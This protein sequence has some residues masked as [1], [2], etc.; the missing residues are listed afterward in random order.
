M[1]T[2]ALIARGAYIVRNAAVCGGCHSAQPSDPDGP[3]T[4]GLEFKDW[5]LGTI[6]AANLTPDSAT[7]LGTWSDGE[8]VRA[9]RNGEAKDGRLLAPVMPYT[10][11]REMSDGDA[12][13]VARYLKSLQPV[14]HQVRESPNLMFRIGKLL[15]LGPARGASESTPPRGPTVQY[16]AYLA[17]HVALCAEC[18]TPRS[19]LRAAPDRR[20]LLAGDAHPPKDFPANPANVTPD[21][22]TGIGTWSERDFVGTLR[23]GVDPKGDSLNPFMPWRQFR[24][25]TDA[26]LVAIYHYLR[27]VKPIHHEVP[28]RVTT[29][30]R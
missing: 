27:V 26:D 5:R 1:D 16:G 9:V 14:R 2:G 13:A 24:R 29:A 10:W 12:L 19:G 18:H 8:I 28:R 6:R 20:R 22:A 7:G 17:Q 21:R 4:G 11:F 3:L 25:M 23:T 30:R 15:F